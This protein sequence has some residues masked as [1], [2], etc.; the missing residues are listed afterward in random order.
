MRAGSIARRLDWL[1]QARL[2]ARALRAPDRVE[3]FWPK[4]EQC[5]EDVDAVSFEDTARGSQVDFRAKHHGKEDVIRV[6]LGV[7]QSHDDYDHFFQ[8][9]LRSCRFFPRDAQQG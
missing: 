6:E 5:G 2:H 8:R 7:A 1:T 3:A 4:C 9:A